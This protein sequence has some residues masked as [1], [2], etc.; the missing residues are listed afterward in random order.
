MDVTVVVR[1]EI[2][3]VIFCLLSYFSPAVVVTTVSAAAAV[4]MDVVVIAVVLSSSCYFCVVASATDAVPS[5]NCQNSRRICNISSLL[6]KKKVRFSG[7]FSLSI[8]KAFGLFF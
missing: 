1:E 7:P 2:T 6:C 5:A 8:M 4:A 3:A